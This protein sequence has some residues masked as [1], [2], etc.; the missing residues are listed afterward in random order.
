MQAS[1]QG[2]P[3]LGACRPPCVQ[4]AAP[5]LMRPNCRGN[6]PRRQDLL[7]KA[8][9]FRKVFPP[10]SRANRQLQPLKARTFLPSQD[11]RRPNV[12]VT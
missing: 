11:E 3:S 9:K 6:L 1:G 4:L 8:W 12:L 5:A 10:R 7:R 2:G